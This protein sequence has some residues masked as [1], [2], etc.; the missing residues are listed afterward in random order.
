MDVDPVA[1]G[2]DG[3]PIDAD[4]GPANAD[5]GDPGT[6]GEIIVLPEVAARAAMGVLLASGQARGATRAAPSSA[7]E[8]VPPDG[9]DDLVTIQLAAALAQ[10]LDAAA[11]RPLARARRA[12]RSQ[13]N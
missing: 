4:P 5:R 11:R 12:L 10:R 1:A 9:V 3:R 7:D 8:V 6:A 2:G 13:P